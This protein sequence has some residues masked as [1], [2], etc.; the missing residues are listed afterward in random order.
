M[1]HNIAQLNDA[2]APMNGQANRLKI[3]L[4]LILLCK[5]K[6]RRVEHLPIKIFVAGFMTA[7]TRLLSLL[8]YFFARA[9]TQFWAIDTFIGDNEIPKIIVADC[10]LEIWMQIKLTL[11]GVLR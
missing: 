10:N 8:V 4:L 6:R 5:R 7:F 1:C 2:H 3:C 11:I 9:H